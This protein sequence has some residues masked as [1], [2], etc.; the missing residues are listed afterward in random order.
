[1]PREERAPPE[2]VMPAGI[3]PELAEAV[4]PHIRLESGPGRGNFPAASLE[5][6]RRAAAHWRVRPGEAMIRLLRLGVWPLR[7]AR[8]RGVMTAEEQAILL[9]SRAAV[10]G[11]GGLGGYLATLLARLGVGGLALCD[12]DV[13]DES[14]LNRQLAARET[15][16]GRNKAAVLSEEI[17]AVASHVDVRVFPV[18]A[19]AG[20]LPEILGGCAIAVDCLDSLP[21]RLVA[22][23]ASHALGIPFVHG[24]LAGDEGFFMT[25]RPGGG[26][27]VSLYGGVGPEDGGGAEKRLGV[28]PQTPAIIAGMEAYLAREEIGTAHV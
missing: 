23:A 6:V 24:S 10:L 20:T 13:F 22:E 16:L 12:F 2:D 17:R 15:S 27:L 3:P 18:A 8:N 19:D 21:S 7:F 28:P 25:S 9:S 14:N 26:G 4:R 1:M 11:C 5:G